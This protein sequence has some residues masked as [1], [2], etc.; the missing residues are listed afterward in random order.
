MKRIAFAAIALVFAGCVTAQIPPAS[1]RIP[2]PAQPPPVSI[3]VEGFVFSDE[4]RNSVRDPGEPGIPEVAVSNGLDVVLTDENGRYRLNADS[5][6][7]LFAV[8][9][10]GWVPPTSAD[11]LPRYFYIHKPSGST[12]DLRFPGIEPTGPLPTTV[13]FPFIAKHEPDRFQMILFGD[14]QP[15]TMEEIDYLSEDVIEEV[16]GTDA[17]FGMTLGD[18]VGDDLSLFAPLN[19]AIARIG[20]P[21]YNLLGNHDIDYAA[22]GDSESDDAFQ[23]VYGP[24][25]YAFQ[26][27]SVHFI[28][29]DTIVYHG[30]NVEDGS[31]GGYGAGL[32]ARQLAFVRN[33]LRVVPVDERVVIAMHYPLKD[34]EQRRELL[35]TISSHPYTL[36]LS[37]HTHIQYHAFYA[38]SDGY[39]SAYPHHHINQ[40]AVA[41]SWWQGTK[42]E[43]GIPHA[44][45]RDGA[46]NGWSV[47]EFDGRDYAV[48]FKAARH[49]AS[50]QMNI[51]AP[52]SVASAD[53]AATEV[54]VNVF[55]GSERSSVEM[56]LGGVDA[57]EMWT[58][59]VLTDRKDPYYVAVR[60]REARR[61]PLPRFGLPPPDWSRHIWV[62][63]LP[64]S[65]PPGTHIIEVRTTDMFGQTYAARRL[66]RIE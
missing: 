26:V 53:T 23:E 42:D 57:D 36:S 29:L 15:Y 41:G 33:Y 64:D 16:V 17:A 65:I 63:R 1:T 51:F 49:P 22:N 45:M 20:I 38:E 2:Q 43:R 5:D 11:L 44:T 40:A 61:R 60:E 25:T 58:P 52:E 46:P 7:I 12:D 21:W 19:R 37:G 47:I 18:L 54:L 28:V 6:T 62:G 59:L 4:N 27:G 35:E 10:R 13:D 66:I 24:A 32:S 31:N 50:Y 34:L 9:P 8:K 39:A 3:P 30:R 14:T 48:R 55:A 56:R